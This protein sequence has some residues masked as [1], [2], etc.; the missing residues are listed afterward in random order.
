MSNNQIACSINTTECTVVRLTT[1]GSTGYSL[2]TCKTFQSGLGELASGKRKRILNKLERHLKEWPK[3]DIAL[4]VEPGNYLPLPAY[5]PA[6]ASPEE[7]KEYSAIEAGFFLTQPEQYRCENTRYSDNTDGE[8]LKKHL[9]LFYPE[10]QCRT[11]SEF[12]S[13]NHRIVFSGSPQLPMLYLSRLTE[14]P[15]VIL[16]L[17]NNYVLLSISR[18]GRIDYFSFHQ[19]KNREEREYFAIKELVYNPVCRETSVQVTG[20]M[21]DTMIVALIGKET[22]IALKT[23]GIP[24]SIS[25]S[26]P[27]NFSISSVS[28]VKAISTALMALAENDGTTTFSR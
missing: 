12:F 9:L 11:V 27:H 8:L 4:C 18:N 22:S 2:S 24:P 6:E 16:E 15:Q 21:A 10:E 14:E 13:T 5:F 1:S 26:N 25:I 3:E 23:F 7:C 19:V 20:T 17:E 28:A